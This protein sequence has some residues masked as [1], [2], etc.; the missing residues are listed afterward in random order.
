MD[1]PEGP[2]PR[3]GR[4]GSLRDLFLVE[5][6]ERG[7][8]SAL[9]VDRFEV[10]RADWRQFV[11]SGAGR[12]V[13]A[14]GIAVGGDGALP[15]CNVDLAM[16]R[17]FAG[18][19]FAR[20]PREDEWR[21]VTQGD[22]R[23]LFP[24]GSKQDPTRAN[25]GELGLGEPT[26]VGTFESGR[27]AN[28]KAPYDLIGNVSEWTESVPWSWCSGMLDVPISYA[29]SV[30]RARQT[31]ALAVW[32]QAG[33]M[34]PVGA[35]VAAGGD[36]VP[37]RVVGGDFQTPMIELYANQTPTERRQRTGFRLYTTAWE[38]VWVLLNETHQP[39]QVDRAQLQ[40]FVRRGRHAEILRAIVELPEMRQQPAGP[41]GELLL[42]E[43]Q[44]AGR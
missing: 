23:S 14:G 19:R 4:F 5:R 38:L 44:A 22:G 2:L 27:K 10:T 32:Q 40:R 8:P 26:P 24:W 6:F 36:H 1:G 16:A 43:L 30:Q 15:V 31:P 18:W 33:G 7:A 28:S 25:T 41:V 35:V 11:A 42:R 13:G 12:A 20:L 17:A 37:R 29:L 39:D 3:T 21:L 9:F 34:M